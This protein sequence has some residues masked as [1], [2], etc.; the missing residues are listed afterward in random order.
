MYKKE[1]YI[2]VLVCFVGK[3]CLIY[4]YSEEWHYGRVYVQDVA[5]ISRMEEKM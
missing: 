4:S 5:S 3:P 2:L 1:L